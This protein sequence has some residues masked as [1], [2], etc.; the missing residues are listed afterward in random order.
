MMYLINRIKCLFLKHDFVHAGQCPYTGA[1]YDVCIR[2]TI[3][4]PID[5]V[6]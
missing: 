1:R 3:T 5:E 6:A 2:C 4:V